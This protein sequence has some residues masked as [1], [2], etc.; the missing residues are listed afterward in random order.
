MARWVPVKLTICNSQFTE[1]RQRL[2]EPDVA[3]VVVYPP[4]SPPSAEGDAAALRTEVRE[5]LRVSDDTAIV[6]HLGRLEPGKGHSLLFEAAATLRDVA[7]WQVLCV[8]GAIGKRDEAHKANLENLVANLGLTDKV[9]FLGETGNAYRFYAAADIYCQPSVLPESFGITFVE[10]MYAGLPVVSTDIGA[11]KE[12]VTEDCGTLVPKG[13]VAGLSA[14]LR[15]L[16]VNVEK[17]RK[18]GEAGPKR[19]ASLA[20]PRACMSRLFEVLIG[21]AR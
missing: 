16:I 5:E 10:A 18:L 4:V 1:T 14:T 20:D 3:T 12:V 11:A 21:Q 9:R 13:D 7:N 19:A 6:L 15:D 8:G 2:Q 17:R